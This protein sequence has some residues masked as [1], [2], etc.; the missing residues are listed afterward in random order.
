MFTIGFVSGSQ[1]PIDL[2]RIIEKSIRLQGNNTGSAQDL[3][4]VAAAIAAHRIAPVIDR[5]YALDRLPEAFAALA[6]G[7]SHFGKLAVTLDF[8]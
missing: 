3:A 5:T 2:M 4:D 6:G 7:G 1:A 8:A